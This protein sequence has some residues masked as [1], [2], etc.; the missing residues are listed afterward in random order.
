MFEMTQ[1]ANGPSLEMDIPLDGRKC[2]APGSERLRVRQ[3]IVENVLPWTDDNHPFVL[4]QGQAEFHVAPA[5]RQDGIGSLGK[6]NDRIGGD[7]IF[8]ICA[9]NPGAPFRLPSEVKPS[10]RH[11]VAYRKQ[12]LA[13]SAQFHTASVSGR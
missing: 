5:G 4:S 13:V 9:G 6:N 10:G 3:Q 2:L 7:E 1:P 11:S 8:T 12:L